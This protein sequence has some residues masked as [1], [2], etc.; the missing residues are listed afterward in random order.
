V[1]GMMSLDDVLYGADSAT[2]GV[3]AATL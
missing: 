1:L 2:A 3:A